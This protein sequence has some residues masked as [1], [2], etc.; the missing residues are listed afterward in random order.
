MYQEGSWKQ[1]NWQLYMGVWSH[2]RLKLLKSVT[3]CYKFL[4]S[5]V[6]YGNNESF[7]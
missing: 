2:D 4:L 6:S 7:C 5:T 1:C 3:T